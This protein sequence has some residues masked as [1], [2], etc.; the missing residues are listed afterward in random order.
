MVATSSLIFSYRY[1]IGF[2]LLRGT[3]CQLWV[4]TDSRRNSKRVCVA[5]SGCCAQERYI[6]TI[7]N[8]CPHLLRYLA[9]AI[10][11]N[12]RRRASLKDLVRIISIER[13]NYSV[14]RCGVAG[15]HAFVCLGSYNFA[16]LCFYV[17]GPDHQ[18]H[19]AVVRER[20]L[21]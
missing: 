2:Q 12:P 11:T 17:P 6:N 15:R 4:E 10:I 16:C 19:R 1:V 5:S 9:V 14:R 20:Q 21:R 7:Q 3:A 8:I 13:A 18:F